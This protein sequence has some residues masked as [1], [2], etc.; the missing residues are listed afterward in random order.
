MTTL[1]KRNGEEEVAPRSGETATPILLD[2]CAEKAEPCADKAEPCASKPPCALSADFLSTGDLA[3][4]CETTLRTVRFYEETGLVEPSTRSEGGHRM[5]D[6]AQREKLQLIMDLREAG[7][8]IQDIKELFALKGRC[9]SATEA[10]VRMTATLEARVA[11]LQRKIVVLRR[12][13]DEL[14]SMVAVVRECGSC[15]HK[16]TFTHQCGGCDVMEREDLPR[17]MRL[18]WGK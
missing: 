7:L 13:R 1:T 5:Y 10:S 6:P 8:S 14:S 15:E 2:P 16:G 12:L 9:G 18:L 4:A 3:R 17:A 11:D